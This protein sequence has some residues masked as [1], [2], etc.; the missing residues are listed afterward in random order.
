[1]ANKIHAYVIRGGK[2]FNI[3]EAAA[4]NGVRTRYMAM[5]TWRPGGKRRRAAKTS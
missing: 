1:M 4:R 2:H 5:C 3:K